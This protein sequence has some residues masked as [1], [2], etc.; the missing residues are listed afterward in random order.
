MGVRSGGYIVATGGGVWLA[1]W[2]SAARE[3]QI[4]FDSAVLG[5]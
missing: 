5:I 4:D 3:P 1:G 2:L